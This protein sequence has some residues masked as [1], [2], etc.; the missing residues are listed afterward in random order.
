MIFFSIFIYV[1]FFGSFSTLLLASIVSRLCMSFFKLLPK[2]KKKTAFHSTASILLF[3]DFYFE[4]AISRLAIS[5][6]PGLHMTSKMYSYYYNYYLKY[7]GS[8]VFWGGIWVVCKESFVKYFKNCYMLAIC[9][10]TCP[11]CGILG[12]RS[13]WMSVNNIIKL[14]LIL[15]LWNIEYPFCVLHPILKRQ[16]TLKKILRYICKLYKKIYS[17]HLAR[18]QLKLQKGILRFKIL[19]LSIYLLRF[20]LK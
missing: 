18:S 2:L 17:C 6:L 8:G 16:N 13:K 15:L 11:A 12:F 20:C 3:V 10:V 5:A 19:Q 4:K 7:K 14:L 1:A 9:I